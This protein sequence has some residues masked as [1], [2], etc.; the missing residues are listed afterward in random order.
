MGADRR[1]V[2]LHGGE[3][4]ALRKR[5]R[6]RDLLASALNADRTLRRLGVDLSA[7]RELDRRP[8]GDDLVGRDAG[9]DGWGCNG[10]GCR[11]SCIAPDVGVQTGSRGAAGGGGHWGD[12]SNG[13][14]SRLGPF[15]RR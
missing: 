10:I 2:E 9:T 8:W 11:R 15:T 14:S 13:A 4:A 3:A 7:E 12:S 6:R 1:V 5:D